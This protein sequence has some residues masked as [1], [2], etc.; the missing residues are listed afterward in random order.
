LDL[1]DFLSIAKRLTSGEGPNKRFGFGIPY[2][3][4]GLTPFWY[5]SGTAVLKDNLTES[6][7]DDPKFLEAVKFIH[8]LV[9]EQ[10]VSPAPANTDP[11]AVFQLFAAGKIAMTGGGHWP[12]QF[13]KANQ[14]RDYDVVPWPKKSV[15]KTVFGEA[16][17][18]ISS[19][20]KQK[21]IAWENGE[22]IGKCRERA[23]GG[24]LRRSHPCPAHG[25]RVARV[26]RPTGARGALLPEPHLRDTGSS[27]GKLR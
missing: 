9:H 2:F 10:G 25:G 18:G 23:P 21:A 13:F 1:D 7:L 6:N 12:M 24:W 4:F 11:N 8:G 22:R 3:N 27:P 5:S 19:R 20:T 17:W 14:F 15:K 16:G 26:S